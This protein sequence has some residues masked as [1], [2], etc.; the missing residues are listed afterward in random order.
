MQPTTTPTISQLYPFKSHSFTNAGAT[1]RTGPTLSQLKKAYS[2][3]NWTQNNNF[4]NMVND[5]G[6]Q[7]WTVP[8]TGNYTIQAVGAAGGNSG[9]GRNVIINNVILTKSEVIKILVG[10]KGT[11]IQGPDGN[12]RGGGGGGGTFVV[13]D[14]KTAIIVAGGGGGYGEGGSNPST[15]ASDASASNKGNNGGDGYGGTAQGGSNGSGG[16][17]GLASSGGGGLLGDGSDYT[18]TRV[19]TY[20]GKAF[21]NGGVGGSPAYDRNFVGIGGGGGSY[22]IS[23]LTDNGAINTGHGSVTITLQ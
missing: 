18:E 16:E 6:I 19:L 3:V 2:S 7:L 23:T 4:L 1:G 22:A 14:V 10:Q 5:N 9:R 15:I 21:I 17:A 20:G 8:V 11:Y 13:R 12:Y